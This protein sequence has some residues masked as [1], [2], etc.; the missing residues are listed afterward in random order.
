[1]FVYAIAQK[2]DLENQ[3]DL[4]SKQNM[5]G[6]RRPL[7]THHSCSRERRQPCAICRNESEY[8]RHVYGFIVQDKKLTLKVLDRPCGAPCRNPYLVD[9]SRAF[10]RTHSFGQ[11]LKNSYFTRDHG[12]GYAVPH[13]LLG[14]GSYG[15]SFSGL[16]GQCDSTVI[17]VA[18]DEAS[19]LSAFNTEQ[20][21]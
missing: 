20:T 11:V 4:Y 18:W 9:L 10:E 13:C 7:R 15:A 16:V 2:H 1:M 6:K 8:T 17:K 14:S 12:I 5:V 19:Q 3:T 21:L